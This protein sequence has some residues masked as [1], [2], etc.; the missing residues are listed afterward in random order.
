MI[1]GS[2]SDLFFSFTRISQWP[3]YVSTI[4]KDFVRWFKNNI[5]NKHINVIL[6]NS[7]RDHL[8]AFDV[9]RILNGEMNTRSVEAL[10][11]KDGITEPKLRPSHNIVEGENVLI[12][13]ALT[14]TGNSIKTLVDI[15]NKY[16]ANLL[17][18]C[19]FVSRNINITEILKNY[20]GEKIPIYITIEFNWHHFSEKEYKMSKNY[21]LEP[22]YSKDI[23]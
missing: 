21:N 6:S 17:G 13:T 22:K 5:K 23:R 3:K 2:H 8:L 9:A 15:T 10:I 11:N 18:I 1:S 16:N 12:V 14:T 20:I 4:S 7:T 19:I